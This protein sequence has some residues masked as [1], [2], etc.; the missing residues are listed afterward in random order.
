[1]VAC[2]ACG[3]AYNLS[4]YSDGYAFQ[5]RCGAEL[6]LGADRR[7]HLQEELPEASSLAEESDTAVAR[8]QTPTLPPAYASHPHPAYDYSAPIQGG[9]HTSIDDVDE[10]EDD[11]LTNAT[12]ST[13]VTQNPYTLLSAEMEMSPAPLDGAA[14]PS[15]S[16]QAH[17]ASPS[18]LVPS[19]I[20]SAYV[21]PPHPAMLYPSGGSMSVYEQN[22]PASP[23]PPASPSY[24]SLNRSA[25][26]SNPYLSTPQHDPHEAPASFGEAPHGEMATIRS[27]SSPISAPAQ[28]SSPVEHVDIQPLATDSRALTA[29]FSVLFFLGPL[30]VL[31]GIGALRRIRRQRGLLKGG[32]LAWFSIVTGLGQSAILLL[33]GA[34]WLF[35]SQSKTWPGVPLLLTF[36]GEPTQAKRD[37]Y[38]EGESTQE[39]R[40]TE[41][42][43]HR[44]IAHE[45][46]FLKGK[47]MQKAP[48]HL[49]VYQ[50]EGARHAFVHWHN[51]ETKQNHRSLFLFANRS[52]WYLGLLDAELPFEVRCKASDG[53][54]LQA[55]TAERLIGCFWQLRGRFRQTS[56]HHLYIHQ[57]P[58]SRSAHAYWLLRKN[59]GTPQEKSW[60]LR[61]LFHRS[62]QGEWYLSRYAERVPRGTLYAFSLPA[63]N[64]LDKESTQKLLQT[65]VQQQGQPP[66]QEVHITPTLHAQAHAYWQQQ[67]KIWE[68]TFRYTNQG[69]WNLVAVREQPR[70]FLNETS[71]AQT[72]L[73]EEEAQRLLT[74]FGRTLPESPMI[75]ALQV[76]Q[77]PDQPYAYAHWSW[78][79]IKRNK[80]RIDKETRLFISLFVRTNDQRWLLLDAMQGGSWRTTQSI[81]RDTPDGRFAKQGSVLMDADLARELLRQYW[82]EDES[83][84]GSQI[85]DLYIY[86]EPKT[87]HALAHWSLDNAGSLKT[88]RTLFLRSQR[89]AWYLGRYAL[90]TPSFTFDFSAKES[91]RLPLETANLLIKKALDKQEDASKKRLHILSPFVYQE[92]NQHKAW[93]LWVLREDQEDKLMTS[94]FH[95]SNQ[96]IWYLSSLQTPLHLKG[97]SPSQPATL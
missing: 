63:P 81:D 38:P 79:V 48:R 94:L 13:A 8:T 12:E 28:A 73:T 18:S 86:Q 43:A 52:L 7:L 95:R 59:K 71:T 6:F 36:L 24:G 74:Q 84:A 10:D 22:P 4:Q 96:G 91:P 85:R 31:L 65:Y 21:P 32:V 58:K 54:R 17:G 76:Y 92:P 66:P 87:H 55:A 51:E 16:P 2:P 40:L 1:M 27:A 62:K 19:S 93:V 50:E 69:S 57:P 39:P 33:L 14:S 44:L 25:A 3:K 45:W 68:G 5:C 11:L 64:I 53:E 67:R 20:P 37:P 23:Y 56:I 72:K 15:L 82:K 80:R 9:E 78:P 75:Q 90:P 77:E 60:Y 70:A 46:R 61:S 83:F 97:F 29:F 41:E 47:A 26:P 35:P 88:M 89:G 49:F 30:A 34:A 42:L